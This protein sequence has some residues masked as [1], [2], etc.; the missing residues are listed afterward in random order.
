MKILVTHGSERGGTAGIAARIGETLRG[1]GITA[2]VLPAREVRDVG[3]YDAVLVGGALY[4]M[5][6]HADARRFVLRHAGALRERPVWFFSSGPLDDSAVHADIPPT[7]QV[8]QLM[9]L[10]G[11]S[12]HA[13]FGGRLAPD[14]RGFIA[15]SMARTRAGDWR[16]EPHIDAWA[17]RVAR[18]VE[19]ELA[20]PEPRAA[21]R[22]FKP[23]PSRALPVGLC[24]LAGASGLFGGA[25]LVYG[26]NGSVLGMPLSVL[27]HSPFHDFLVPGLLLLLFIGLG[28]T[29]AAF[30]HAARSG[31]ASLASFVSGGALVVWMVSEMIM[32]RSAHWLQVGYLML[33]AAIV[34]ES[35]HQVRLIVPPPSTWP[36]APSPG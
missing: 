27:D 14:A 16:D 5:L 9:D 6:W 10:V 25:A 13:T 23:L 7:R 11:A 12:G 20:R 2:D 33:G 22:D 30:L 4:A 34:A 36:R 15:S 26:P 28:N 29:W 35:I 8:Q 19:A 24:L 17:L 31:S 32:L 1:A 18:R 3:A 21:R